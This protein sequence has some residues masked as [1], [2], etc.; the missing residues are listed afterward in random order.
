MTVVEACAPHCARESF[1]REGYVPAGT[2][3]QAM[4]ADEIRHVFVIGAGTMGQQIALQCAM[5]G[6]DVSVYDVSP[7]AL[8]SVLLGSSASRRS[9]GRRSAAW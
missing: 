2:Q 9:S 1:H 7:G 6:C 5:H 4:T 8:Q 3:E